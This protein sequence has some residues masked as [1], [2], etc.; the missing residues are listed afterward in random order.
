MTRSSGW[1]ALY[2]GNGGV[3]L[4]LRIRSEW[5]TSRSAIHPSPSMRSA[6]LSNPYSRTRLTGSGLMY[7]TPNTEGALRAP[8]SNPRA[9]GTM[10]G[11]SDRQDC[12]G[13][14]SGGASPPFVFGSGYGK[15]RL[16]TRTRAAHS[17]SYAAVSARP[18]PSAR[19]LNRR[20]GSAGRGRLGDNV[21]RLAERDARLPSTTEPV[22]CCPCRSRPLGLC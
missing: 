19:E 22:R 15:P 17:P 11:R 4:R 9:M 16:G 8:T 13:V 1:A 2:D 12:L 20:P 14:D 21:R 18:H 10:I 7:P 5:R 3:T 6:G